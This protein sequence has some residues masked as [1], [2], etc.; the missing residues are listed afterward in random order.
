MNLDWNQHYC[1]KT[2]G[3]HFWVTSWAMR[4]EVPR[5]KLNCALLKSARCTIVWPDRIIKHD[6]FPSAVWLSLYRTTQNNPH[7]PSE[8]GSGQTLRTVDGGEKKLSFSP[9]TRGCRQTRFGWDRQARCHSSLRHIIDNPTT[10]SRGSSFGGM[11]SR[12]LGR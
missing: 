8:A 11:W 9:V 3:K 12:A 4:L 7:F 2:S 5:D 6:C 1:N 10:G